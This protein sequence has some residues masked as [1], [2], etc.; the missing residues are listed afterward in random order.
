MKVNLHT[1]TFRCGHAKGSEREYIERAI[2]GGITHMGFSEHSPFAFPDGH[3]SKHRV[4]MDSV[5]EYMETLNALREEYKSDIKIYIGFEMEYYP[6]YFDDMLKTV[7][8]FGAE[9]LLLG[10]HYL[11]N[12][13][14]PSVL[15]KS[16]TVLYPTMSADMLKQY[17]D[18]V[19]MGIESGVFSYVAHPDMMNFFGD[20]AVY[21]AQ[22]RRICKSAKQYGMPV[23]LNFLGIRSGRKYP[24]ERFW[25]IVGQEGC[26]VVFGFDA[27]APK[28]AYDNDS[29]PCAEWLVGEYGLKLLEKPM[30]V[31]PVTKKRFEI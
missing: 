6:A 9:Y 17:A 5:C 8:S 2:S 19:I 14:V 4:A 28:D 7:N 3:Q 21:D 16:E 18:T 30:L 25:K 26:D 13:Y 23:E 1:H 29:L 11:D 15:L 24:Q 22:M 27:H 10:Q 20:E 31:D 12:E